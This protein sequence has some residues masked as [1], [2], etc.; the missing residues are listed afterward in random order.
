MLHVLFYRVIM[1]LKVPLIVAFPQTVASFA[2]LFVAV[3]EIPGA[4]DRDCT[5]QGFFLECS[6]DL[7][8]NDTK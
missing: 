6:W 4:C 1:L 8:D 2:K 7:S 3:D 5:P